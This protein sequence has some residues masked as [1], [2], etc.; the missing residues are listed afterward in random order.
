MSRRLFA[1]APDGTLVSRQTHKKYTHAVIIPRRDALA[2]IRAFTG[3]ETWAV[4]GWTTNSERMLKE[5]RL[6]YKNAIVVPVS[7]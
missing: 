5:A 7:T 1:K 6:Y 3:S 2:G 4:W